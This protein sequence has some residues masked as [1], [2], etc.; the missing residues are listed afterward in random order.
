[1]I[2]TTYIY[3]IVDREPYLISVAKG[4]GDTL[5]IQINGGENA[6]LRVGNISTN[7]TDGVGR[8]KLSTLGEGVFTPEVIFKDK[9]VRLYPIR[10]KTGKVSLACPEEMLAALGARSFNTEA[11]VS[12]T[13]KA[14][15]ALNDAVWGK[16]IF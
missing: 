14:L 8:V 7:M 10:H 9:T 13:E 6:V 4:T 1:L 15:Q 5:N 16:A 2:M 3:N 12:A 11:R